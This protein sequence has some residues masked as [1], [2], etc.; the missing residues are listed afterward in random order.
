ME[1]RATIGCAVLLAAAATGPSCT[2]KTVAGVELANAGI[3]YGFA[4]VFDGNNLPTRVTQPFGIVAGAIDFG[5][6]PAL[7]LRDED[8]SFVI[9]AL[10]DALVDGATR[11]S[12]DRARARELGV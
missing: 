6:T 9:V 10:D 1:R 5:E 3:Q 4:V 11:R 8:Q 2:S 7:E 12:F